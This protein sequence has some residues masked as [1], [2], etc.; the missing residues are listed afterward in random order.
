M[1]IKRRK[2]KDLSLFVKKQH[3]IEHP[4]LLILSYSSEKNLC[5]STECKETDPQGHC[6]LNFE[7]KQSQFR[8]QMWVSK[9]AKK[10]SISQKSG[11]TTGCL[12]DKTCT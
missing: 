8:A 3:T 4:D 10:E 12:H 5:S 9:V 2:I 7:T 6:H 1:L 11:G